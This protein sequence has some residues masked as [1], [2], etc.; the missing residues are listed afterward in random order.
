MA[1]IVCILAL[2]I[3]LTMT[4]PNVV[5]YV[6]I[7]PYRRLLWNLFF[8]YIIGNLYCT[9]FS[10]VVGSGI[11]VELRPFMSIA[12]LF[13]E[14]MV[15]GGE[16]AGFFAWFMNG[17][18]PIASLILNI[19]LYYPLGYLLPILFPKFK[20]KYVILI[21]CLCSIATETMQYLLRMGWCE[22]DDVIFNTLGTAI[23]VWVWFRQL[24][25]LNAQNVQRQRP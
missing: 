12:R 18:T 23:G 20:P 16:T 2:L 19:L 24:K 11:M 13:Q 4:V 6:A 3:C 7:V 15:G 1:Q 10:R 5:R 22:T 8:V 9:T 14:P 21:G 25:R 17:A